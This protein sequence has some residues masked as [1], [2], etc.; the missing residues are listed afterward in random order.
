MYSD[1][2]KDG[3][4]A[5]KSG[6]QRTHANGELTFLDRLSLN[7]VSHT[8]LQYHSR[9]V[10]LVDRVIKVEVDFQHTL[11]S[12]MFYI[13]DLG[14]RVPVLVHVAMYDPKR[15]ELLRATCCEPT[16]TRSGFGVLNV[17]FT[18]LFQAFPKVW[19]KR[20]IALY[21]EFDHPKRSGPYKEF[22]EWSSC[23]AVLASRTPM[24]SV[25][26]RKSCGAK[27]PGL[28]TVASGLPVASC[29]APL[30]W[31]FSFGTM[32]GHGFKLVHHEVVTFA[33]LF[34]KCV[35]AEGAL[36]SSLEYSKTFRAIRLA[37]GARSNVMS[38]VYMCATDVAPESFEPYNAWA[39]WFREEMGML[40][41]GVFG[42]RKIS[43]T[44]NV[45]SCTVN[46]NN[47][48]V[49]EV[50]A[51]PDY[52]LVGALCATNLDDVQ[53]LWDKF[54]GPIVPFTPS[55]VVT[56]PTNLSDHRRDEIR[57]LEMSYGDDTFRVVTNN[58]TVSRV[59]VGSSKEV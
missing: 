49:S 57:V 31:A 18:A 38:A 59:L 39:V 40:C 3:Y 34:K 43:S 27:R 29:V 58:P 5:P 23:V 21:V 6:K 42:S 13:K 8:E 25:G 32:A 7:S 24:C 12:T 17:H 33:P 1:S 52:D 9:A 48:A 44:A 16:I 30:G 45:A 41:P 54:D 37:E 19:D 35:A 53:D 2:K 28:V 36:P 50:L 22:D 11:F 14:G 10:G 4:W 20:F 15:G 51:G 55:P 26:Y 56:L 46:E 47:P